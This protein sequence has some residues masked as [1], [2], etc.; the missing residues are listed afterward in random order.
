MTL[1]GSEGAGV[2]VGGLAGAQIKKAVLEL[3]GS[4]PFIVLPSADLDKAAATAVQA[5]TI[6]NGQSCIAAKR[7]IVHQDVYD[8]FLSQLRRRH[9][10]AAGRRPARIRTP[11]SVRSR[12]APIRDELADQVARS[13]A[14]GARVATGGD[15][16]PGPATSTPRPCWSIRSRGSPAWDEELFGPVATRLRGARIWTRPIAVANHPTFGLGASAW[17]SDRAEQERLAVRDRSRLGLHQRHGEER[18]AAAVR[19]DQ[20]LGLRARAGGGGDSRVREYQDGVGG[21]AKP[22]CARPP[23]SS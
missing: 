15:E 22:R 12:T 5:R 23:L 16:L 8:E 9:G 4:D 21:V 14:A 17:T 6:N 3:G 10:G 20:A 2:A 19:R 7:F 18:S 13:V 1:T 11:R